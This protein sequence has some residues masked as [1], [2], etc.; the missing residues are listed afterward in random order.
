MVE[1]NH[2]SMKANIQSLVSGKPF[3]RNSLEIKE[4]EFACL[5]FILLVP[6][7][8]EGWLKKSMCEVKKNFN[9]ALL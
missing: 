4:A 1:Q 3:L 8:K 9:Q 7:S 5:V 2:W 6:V